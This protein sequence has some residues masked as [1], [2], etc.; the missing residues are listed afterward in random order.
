[1]HI[2]RLPHIKHIGNYDNVHENSQKKNAFKIDV[3][4][5]RGTNVNVYGSLIKAFKIKIEH[6]TRLLDGVNHLAHPGEF[7]CGY[8]A[9][10]NANLS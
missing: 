7:I 2:R 4:N 6:Q 10:S 5:I 8:R 9:M 1:M 3:M